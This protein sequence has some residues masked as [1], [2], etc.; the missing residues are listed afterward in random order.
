MQKI[1]IRPR[2]VVVNI[3]GERSKRVLIALLLLADTSNLNM[4]AFI[5]SEIEKLTPEDLLLK[6]IH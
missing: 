2:L 6:F 1:I 3:I 5:V 4:Y